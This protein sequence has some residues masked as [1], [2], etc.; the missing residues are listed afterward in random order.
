LNKKKILVVC[1]NA[2][3]GKNLLELLES[4]G[5]EVEHLSNPSL[6]IKNITTNNP[7]IILSDSKFKKADA[8]EILKS[9]KATYEIPIIFLEKEDSIEGAVL[10]LK[11]GATDYFSQP[12]DIVRL[13][14]VLEN[15]SDNIDTIEESQ[16]LK[17]QLQ[18]LKH[19]N[20]RLIGNSPKMTDIFNQ[21]E[22]CA[23]SNASVF[24]TGPS[25][26]GKEL[27]ARAIHDLSTRRKG[28]FIAINCSAIPQ[29]LLE[30]EIFGHEKGSFTGAIKR[31]EGC[32]ELAND[33]TFFLDEITEM[34]PDLQSKI[35]RTLENGTFRRV[36]GT[37]EIKADVRVLAASNKKVPEEIKAGNFREDLFYRL[38]V[39]FF[40][41]PPLKERTS[42]IPLLTQYFID[43][44]N[45]K[46]AKNITSADQQ[47]F[48]ILKCYDWPGNVRELRNVIE[49]AMIHCK[50]NIITREDLPPYIFAKSDQQGP[51]IK[52]DIG[53]TKFQDIEQAVILKT[54]NH[55]NG[56]KVNTAR[57]LGLSLKTLYN[58]LNSY[59]VMTTR[60]D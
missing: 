49:R 34:A 38:N 9:I 33:G 60:Q 20:G 29:T 52:F 48:E 39:F 40:E 14:K 16:R 56:D 5:F 11:S 59:Q 19:L 7:H 4:W 26:T 18:N 32:F 41:L 2:T 1:E 30:S 15:I 13:K 36:G 10:A 21:I 47:V 45:I 25:G 50:S 12:V 6:I 51:L 43:D 58:K 28:P 23:P 31:K 35:L 24:I 17:E 27:V 22:T 54:L 8:V 55:Y 37:E 3:D 44:L 42:D 46:A 57:T 53:A